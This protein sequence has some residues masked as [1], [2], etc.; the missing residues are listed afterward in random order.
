MDIKQGN[1]EREGLEFKLSRI[2]AQEV[3]AA[4]K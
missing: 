3:F 4:G 2:P 1:R